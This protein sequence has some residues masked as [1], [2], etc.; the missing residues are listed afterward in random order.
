MDEELKKILTDVKKEEIK[1]L[2]DELLSSHGME[3]SEFLTS[4]EIEFK[5]KINNALVND[6]GFKNT[7]ISA[8]LNLLGFNVGDLYLP[9]QKEIEKG[10][11]KYSKK[12]IKWL[13]KKISMKNLFG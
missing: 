8:I 2:L 10:V 3:L 4:H 1:K 5:E 13:R 11:K 7:E 12:A 9:L 6:L